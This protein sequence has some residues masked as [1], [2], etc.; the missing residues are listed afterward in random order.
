MFLFLKLW[1]L[2]FKQRCYYLEVSPFGFNLHISALRLSLFTH[3]FRPTSSTPL[4]S[5]GPATVASVSDLDEVHVPADKNL[6]AF[7]VHIAT[8]CRTEPF[9]SSRRMAWSNILASCWKVTVMKL[10]SR[11]WEPG[12]QN[13]PLLYCFHANWARRP[14]FNI[15]WNML[16]NQA[17]VRKQTF[18]EQL[19]RIYFKHVKYVDRRR[20][21]CSFLTNQQSVL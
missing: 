18:N 15:S 4:N 2:A 6:L 9:S 11:I 17:A 20:V 19:Y 12:I 1:Q 16:E 10:Q 3:Q 8:S 13:T 21:K 5:A 14:M 7:P